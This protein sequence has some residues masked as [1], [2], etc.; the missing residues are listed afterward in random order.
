MLRGARLVTAIETEEDR[1]W[2][3]SRIKSLT[4]GDRIAAR[5]MKQDFFQFKPQFKLFTAGNHK[6]KLRTVDEAIRRRFNLIP[7]AVT[8]PAEER[9][10]ELTKRLQSEWPGIL[11]WMI[12]G[13]LEWQA[14]GLCPPSAVT[15]A[16]ADYLE[17]EDALAAWLE[18]CCDVNVNAWDFPKRLY[19][20]W[21]GFAE[22]TGDIAG[23]LN[24]FRQKLEN[25][26][27]FQTRTNG[28]RRYLGLRVRDRAAFEP[29]SV[30][31]SVGLID[32]AP[33]PTEDDPFLF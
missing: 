2:A 18:E 4:G 15:N 10:P 19:E 1:R 5:F 29:A 24:G 32:R 22:T 26:G 33:T 8:I 13:C 23:P 31:D 28:K 20:S 14:D 30:P 25:R 12:D 9:D 3:E 17:A 16:T 21:K 7:F 6:P 27:F 11:Q